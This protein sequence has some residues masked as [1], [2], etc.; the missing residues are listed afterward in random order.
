MSEIKS[1]GR[2]PLGAYACSLAAGIIIVVGGVIAA[3]FTITI[4]P[5]F[6]MM[7]PGTGMMGPGMGTGMIGFMGLGSMLVFAGISIGMVS[8]II[9]LVAA[10]LLRTKPKDYQTWGILILI[11]SIISLF[12]MGGF[13]IGSIVGIVGGA[14]ALSWKPQANP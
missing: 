7:F 10:I 8:G 5:S 2:Y 11:F 13:F 12:G 14:L 9:V 4:M 1:D 3:F 6:G